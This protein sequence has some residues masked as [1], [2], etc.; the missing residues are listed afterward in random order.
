MLKKLIGVLALSLALVGCGDTSDT[1]DTSRVEPKQEEAVEEVVDKAVDTD[2]S[3]NV[4][5]QDDSQKIKEEEV[6]QEFHKNMK[7]FNTVYYEESKAYVMIPTSEDLKYEIGS[8]INKTLDRSNWD[9]VVD[10]VVTLSTTLKGYKLGEGYAIM[11][12]NPYNLDNVLLVVKDGVVIYD[13]IDDI[14]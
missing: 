2:T 3:V 13:I 10:S 8:I 11:I 4:E 1:S 14:Y 7:H 6:L 5:S 12:M 9:A